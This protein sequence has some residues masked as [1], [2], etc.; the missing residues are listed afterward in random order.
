MKEY[1][2]IDM[3][4]SIGHDRPGQHTL[5]RLYCYGEYAKKVYNILYT[6]NSLFL[7]R[8]YERWQELL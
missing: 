5:Y 6:P 4:L 8:K 3:Q 7:K 1:Y 2:N